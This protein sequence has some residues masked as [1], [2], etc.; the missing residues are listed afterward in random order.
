MYQKLHT[1]VKVYNQ[2][3]VQVNS[4]LADIARFV[5]LLKYHM[6]VLELKLQ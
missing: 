1:K 6:L 2:N 4:V 3:I 5:M